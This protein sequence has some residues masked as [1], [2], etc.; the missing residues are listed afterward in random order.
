[1]PFI[2]DQYTNWA[3]EQK[4][5]HFPAPFLDR[6]CHS[7]HVLLCYL[8]TA[9]GDYSEES[10]VLTFQPGETEISF[11]VSTIEDTTNEPVESFIVT[12]SNPQGAIL[13]EDSTANV[14]IADDDGMYGLSI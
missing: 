3:P 13:G 7:K 4:L 1:M 8:F 5:V 10:T 9:P 12:L 2:T 11:P 14:D 6:V